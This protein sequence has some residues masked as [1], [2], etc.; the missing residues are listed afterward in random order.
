V[1]ASH[2]FRGYDDE[3]L[4]PARPKSASREPEEAINKPEPYPGMPALQ[5]G[6][7]LTESQVLEEQASAS[8]EK[9]AEARKEDQN[10][11]EHGVLL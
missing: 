8:V 9:S 3:W 7:L 10:E 1:P 5:D 2:R 11:I 6:E 4:L